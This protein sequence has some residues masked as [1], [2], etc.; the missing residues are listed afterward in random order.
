MK[1]AIYRPKYRHY[2]DAQTL[3]SVYFSLI[4]PYL[5]YGAL[6]WGNTY[7]SRVHPLHVLN[8]KA[9]R[10]MTFSH[11]QSH[12][13]FQYIN[14]WIFFNL[15]ISSLR[16]SQLLFMTIII[17]IFLKLS[18]IIFKLSLISITITLATL[19]QIFFYL[20]LALIMANHP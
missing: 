4:Y 11:F 12:A 17:I 7:K 16:K 8:N 5:Y 9:V 3:R 14:L 15:S 6:T 13:S 10:I 1:G 18:Q 2:L 19:N 20:K